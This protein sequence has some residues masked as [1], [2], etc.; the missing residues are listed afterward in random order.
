LLFQDEVFEGAVCLNA[1]EHYREPDRAMQEIRLVLKPGG[2]F[3][4]HTAFLQP[5]HK[6]P[7]RYYNCTEFRLR[8][9]LR[10][11]NMD[12]IR[13]SPNL[14]LVYA[15]SSLASATEAV[16]T[17]TVS[18]QTAALLPSMDSRLRLFLANPESRKSA[19]WNFFYDLLSSVQHKLVAGWEEIATK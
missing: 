8:Y 6:A 10:D 7:H 11:F 9:W 14:N 19:L 4:M 15:L 3:F 18:P 1:F 17:A 5:F 12:C 16:F 2:R 13:V